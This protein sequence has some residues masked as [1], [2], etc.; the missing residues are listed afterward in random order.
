MKISVLGGARFK[1]DAIMYKQALK[2]GQKLVSKKYYLS[3]GGGKGI[4]DAI[5]TPFK[6]NPELLTSICIASDQDGDECYKWHG[7][8]T[9]KTVESVN[10]QSIAL[11]Q[12]KDMIIIFPGG[13]G[14]IHE[15]FCILTNRLYETCKII[16]I[17][18]ELKNLLLY[19]IDSFGKELFNINFDMLTFVNDVD[20]IHL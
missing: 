13:T 14:T 19:C 3:A 20:K 16:L 12:N 5:S 11:T 2:L 7:F 10:E 18:K 1:N 8:G 9:P 4:M 15:L 17:G 6:N